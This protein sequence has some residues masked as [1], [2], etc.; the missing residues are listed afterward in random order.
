MVDHCCH[1]PASAKKGL[2]M[3]RTSPLRF[4]NRISPDTE[5]TPGLDLSTATPTKETH[6]G[7]KIANTVAINLLTPIDPS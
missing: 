2:A 1:L 5:I 3:H 4:R 6:V 7:T